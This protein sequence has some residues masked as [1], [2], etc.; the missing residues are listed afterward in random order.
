M[1]N[2]EKA[3]MLLAF[4]SSLGS[5]ILAVY[6]HTSWEWQFNTMIWVVVAFIKTKTNEKN[7]I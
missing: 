2:L 7:E 6:N 3:F 4:L 1:K 5:L